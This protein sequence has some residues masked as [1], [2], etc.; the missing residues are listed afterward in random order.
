MTKQEHI[1]AIRETLECY[2]LVDKIDLRKYSP[3][4]EALT[5]LTALEAMIKGE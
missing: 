4:K 2:A 5:Q 3:A 1:D